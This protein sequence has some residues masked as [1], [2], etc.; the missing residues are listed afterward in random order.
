MV[1]QLWCLHV[2]NS[3][4]YGLAFAVAAGGRR[5]WLKI[6][7]KLNMQQRQPQIWIP[8]SDFNLYGFVWLCM[9]LCGYMQLNVRL[10]CWFV[11]EMFNDQYN[12]EC[13]WEF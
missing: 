3:Q 8:D 5:H 6:D 12:K 9:A 7:D 13:S 4:L 10:S 2:A 11:V 1:V